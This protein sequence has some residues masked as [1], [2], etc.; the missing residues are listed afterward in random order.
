MV[1]RGSATIDAKSPIR[2][3]HVGI[4][5]D[6]LA[7]SGAEGAGLVALPGLQQP[8]QVDDLVVAPVADVAPGIVRVLGLPVDAGAGD[9]VGV[10]AVGGR[11]VEEDR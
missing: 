8:Q 9:A 3:G 2:Y 11:G 5:V 6:P 10:V 7:Q 4:R 1:W